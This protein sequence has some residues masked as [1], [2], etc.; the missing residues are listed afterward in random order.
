MSAVS[1]SI[2]SRGALIVGQD[3]S[4]QGLCERLIRQFDPRWPVR[5]SSVDEAFAGLARLDSAPDLVIVEPADDRGYGL[6]FLRALR[7]RFG[8]VPVLV[9][10]DDA[11]A[12]RLLET[13]RAGARGYLLKDRTDAGLLRQ[14][15][16]RVMDGACPVSPALMRHLFALVRSG[17]GEGPAPSSGGTVHQLSPRERELLSHLSLASSYTEAAAAMGIKLSTVQSHVRR[18]YRKLAVQSRMQ[19]V[20][21]ARARGLI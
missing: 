19:A 4:W 21:L 11:S 14:A 17:T 8:A 18:L 15:I 7:V 2:A 16:A 3:E 5:S 6:G 9:L 10:S 20:N 12:E 13:I 1:G